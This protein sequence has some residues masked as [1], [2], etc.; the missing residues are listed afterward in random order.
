MVCHLCNLEI[1]VLVK[2]VK[3]TSIPWGM[4][5]INRQILYT[6]FLLFFELRLHFW[7][8][9]MSFS[10]FF[11]YVNYSGSPFSGC[12]NPFELPVPTKYQRSWFPASTQKPGCGM[13][14]SSIARYIIIRVRWKQKLLWDY[15]G[16]GLYWVHIRCYYGYFWI[17]LGF[18]GTRGTRIAVKKKHEKLQPWQ[19]AWWIPGSWLRPDFGPNKSNRLLLT[20]S[21]P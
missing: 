9:L 3:Y 8:F 16:P 1:S 4:P 19:W 5:S 6:P 12:M 7:I 2:Q 18:L 17:P 13:S 10:V 14:S 11:T 21:N 15:L 20:Y